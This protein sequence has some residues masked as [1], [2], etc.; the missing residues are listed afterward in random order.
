MVAYR[1]AGIGQ[2]CLNLLRELAELQ[3]RQADFELTV[4]QSRKEKRPLSE[5]LTTPGQAAA[6]PPES[7]G[8]QP[9]PFKKRTLWTPPHHRFEQIALPLEML[10]FG[11]AVLH[12]PDFIPPLRRLTW[13]SGLP[14]PYASVITIHDLAFKLFPDLLTSESARYY[15]QIA[16]AARSAGRI[17]AVSESTAADIIRQLDVPPDKV[18]VVYEAANPLYRPLGQAGLSQLALAEAAPVAAKLAQ[19]GV[20]EDAAFPLFVSTLEPRKNLPT[21]LQAYRRW[22][23]SAPG[24]ALPKLVIAGRE[25]WLYQEIYRLAGELRLDSQLVWLGEVETPELLYL[26]NRAAFLAMPSLYEGFGL[27]PLEALTCGCPVLVA[28]SSSLPEVAGPV[29]RRIAPQDV[30]AWAGALAESWQERN[31]LKAQALSA[32]TAWA[33]QFSWARAARQTLAVYFE[34]FEQSARAKP[35]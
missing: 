23:D 11:P 33:G 10:P 24:L 8:G 20:S 9:V 27:P 1:Q 6:D 3:S 7:P 17:I 30:A 19:A 4:Y 21:L 18:R 5:W 31:R 29:G 32:G 28:D 34:A 13:R 14:R 26:Y 22:L 16:Q 25:G 15:G 35:V 12:S 2:Y